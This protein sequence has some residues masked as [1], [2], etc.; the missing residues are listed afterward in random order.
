MFQ[1]IFRSTSSVDLS[2]TKNSY[3]NPSTSFR[4]SSVNIRNGVSAESLL[5]RIPAADTS[6]PKFSSEAFKSLES[7]LTRS[8]SNVTLDESR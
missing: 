5:E 1:V 7:L 6:E 3:N 4:N 8:N 2:N